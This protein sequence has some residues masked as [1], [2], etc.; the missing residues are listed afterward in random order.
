MLLSISC[1]LPPLTGFKRILCF[2]L[3]M[4]RLVFLFASVAL[5]LL[6]NVLS[7]STSGRICYMILPSQA[8]PHSRY[9]VSFHFSDSFCWSFTFGTCKLLFSFEMS[10]FFLFAF[11]RATPMAHG[12]SQARG[13]IRGVAAGLH[14]SHS[15]AGSAEPH[16][17]PTPQ[18]TATPDPTEWGQ[19][20]NPQPHGSQLD[21][22]T[23][24]PRWELPEISILSNI[25]AVSNFKLFATYINWENDYEVPSTDLDIW[26]HAL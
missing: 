5:W 20:L 16:L 26:S 19:G 11:P 2:V 24:E 17:C 7:K 25:I 18:L 6:F 22:L 15:N 10:F 14:H 23:T 21:S 4:C 1:L 12:G 9:S 13:L 3:H 8:W